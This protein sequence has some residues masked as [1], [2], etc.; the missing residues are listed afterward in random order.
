M[1]ISAALNL[2]SGSMDVSISLKSSF[3]LIFLID[4]CI[5][6]EAVEQH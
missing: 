1:V 6:C 4:F 2:I 5:P 3:H